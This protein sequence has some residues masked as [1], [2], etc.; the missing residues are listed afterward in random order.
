MEL[1]SLSEHEIWYSEA[2]AILSQDD[3][4]FNG[5]SLQN[6]SII[7]STL[8]YDDLGNV[9]LNA[10]NYPR[11]DGGG[12]LN[13]YYRGRT[14]TLKATIKASTASDF[15][16]LID[17][18]K[19]NL[20][21][22]S[23]YLDIRVNSEIRRIRATVTKTDFNR[24]HYHITFCPLVVTFT[25]LEPFF[26]AYNA[27]SF[28]YL[29]KTATFSEE[30]THRGTADSDPVFYFIFGTGTSVTAITLTNP[31]TTTLVITNTFAIND[32]LIID[33]GNK[34]VTKNGTQIDYTGV[35]PS[36]TPGSN[37]FTFTITW[38]VLVDVTAIVPKNYL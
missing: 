38:A 11:D 3:I 37:P 10:F 28:W 7:T 6:T 30:I 8:D 32:V 1:Y 5:Y 20:K 16:D 15:N 19:Q 14:I 36:F 21:Q 12:V 22:T 23:G 33:A 26:Y 13:K 27:Q 25:V 18:I 2:P 4:V 24:D 31:D 35:F 9:E 29:A 34:I 17:E